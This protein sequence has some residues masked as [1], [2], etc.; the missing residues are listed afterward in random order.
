MAVPLPSVGEAMNQSDECAIPRAERSDS[1]TKVDPGKVFLEHPAPGARYPQEDRNPGEIERQNENA[2]QEHLKLSEH[3]QSQ[4]V[5]EGDSQEDPGEKSQ[6]VGRLPPPQ[7]LAGPVP[8]GQ[9]G[10]QGHDRLNNEREH[11][12]PKD[13][14]DPEYRK[15]C[16]DSGELP[17][18]AGAETHRSTPHRQA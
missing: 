1:R 11:R 13:L 6:R 5:D 8:C 3:E 18:A 12:E 9:Q 15:P 4:Q 2:A 14:A 7:R 17:G 10:E 16:D